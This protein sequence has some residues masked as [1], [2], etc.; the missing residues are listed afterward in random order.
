[1]WTPDAYEGAPLP[2]TAYLSAA[3]KAAGFALLLRLFSEAF[4]PVLGATGAG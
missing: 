1:M 2:I 3:S 4:L